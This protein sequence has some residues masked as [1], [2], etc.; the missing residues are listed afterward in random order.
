[1]FHQKRFECVLI[2][3]VGPYRDFVRG[4]EIDADEGQNGEH[5]M[6]DPDHR[7]KTLCEFRGRRHHARQQDTE[8]VD[9]GQAKEGLDAKGFEDL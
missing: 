1:M 5:A 6:E 8:D 2:S 7:P 9:D 3:I 4:H